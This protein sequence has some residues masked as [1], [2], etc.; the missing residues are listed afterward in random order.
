MMPPS[1][2]ILHHIKIIN[3]VDN[4]SLIKHNFFRKLHHAQLKTLF[5][6]GKQS[7]SPTYHLVKTGFTI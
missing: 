3:D 4:I 6:G 2:F 1:L 5:V 7:Y